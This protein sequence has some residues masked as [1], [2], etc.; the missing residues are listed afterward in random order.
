MFVI[1]A[2]LTLAPMGGNAQVLMER[3]ISLQLALNVAQAAM[4][5][6]QSGRL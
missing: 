2:I 3:N 6:V 1:A 5:A 4:A